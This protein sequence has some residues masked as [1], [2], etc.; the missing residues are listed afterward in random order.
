MLNQLGKKKL[1]HEQ[2]IVANR[3]VLFLLF[4]ILSK[5]KNANIFWNCRILGLELPSPTHTHTILEN[6]V[7]KLTHTIYFG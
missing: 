7:F 2:D 3:L 6:Q 5:H 4:Y 1:K